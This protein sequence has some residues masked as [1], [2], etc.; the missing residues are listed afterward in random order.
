[1][2]GIP[3]G[4]LACASAI[5]VSV[6]LSGCGGKPAPQRSTVETS[7]L[8]KARMAQSYMNAGRV[9]EALAT[10]Q[11]AIAV[12]PGNAALRLQYGQICFQAGRFTDAEAAFQKALEI[13]PYLTDAHNYL[14]TVYQELGRFADAEREYRKALEDPAYP[15]PELVYLNL[16]I[17]YTDQ[18]REEQALE[19]LR[20]AVGINPKYYKAHF[21]LAA[22]LERAGRFDEAAREYEVAEPDFRNNGDYFYRRGFTYFRLG[23]RDQAR[24]MLGRVLTIAP[25]SESAARADELLDMLE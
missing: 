5:L 8:Y 15:T 13:D 23:K 24:D 9:G 21:Q 6:T 14:G 25:G 20:T 3:I 22:L 2:A 10:L 18:E 17:L 19:A 16:G 12:E 11:E 7:A 1:M 4:R